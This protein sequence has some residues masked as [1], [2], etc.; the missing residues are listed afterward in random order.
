MR[1]TF[2]RSYCACLAVAAALLG[3]S[4]GARTQEN[5]ASVVADKIFARKILMDTID[6]RMD[7]IDFMVTSNK[8][9]DFASAVDDA[10]TI[11]AM[12][13]AF[14]HLFPPETNQW[15]QDAKRDPARDTF[16][17]PELWV[18]FADFY[19]RA[20]EASRIALEASQAKKVEE[21]KTHFEAL[22]AACD[23]CHAL[24]VKPGD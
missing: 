1:M 14:P 22:R 12:L 11:S 6:T 10:D 13:L 3:S 7:S 19:R 20:G 23:A 9:M 15:K 17:S 21:F 2:L 4:G 18:K 24:Y 5:S 16:A 8:P